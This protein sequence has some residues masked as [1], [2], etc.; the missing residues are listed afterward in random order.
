ME[1][2]PGRGKGPWQAL[3]GGGALPTTLG[4]SPLAPRVEAARPVA[5]VVAAVVAS[6]SALGPCLLQRTRGCFSFSARPLPKDAWCPQHPRV[7]TSP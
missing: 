1:G 2:L 7:L 6:G 5:A 3:G 4:R